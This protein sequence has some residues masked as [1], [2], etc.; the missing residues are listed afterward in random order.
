VGKAAI[1]A[2]CKSRQLSW[3]FPGETEKTK[4]PLRIAGLRAEILTRDPPNTKQ[5]CQLLDRDFQFFL[6]YMGLKLGLPLLV[7]LRK[8]QVLSVFEDRV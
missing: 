7:T 1:T 2:W 4:K 6:P 8:E 5:E 3:H